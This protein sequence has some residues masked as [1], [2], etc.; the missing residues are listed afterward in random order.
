[1]IVYCS[2]HTGILASLI[3][4][5]LKLNITFIICFHNVRADIYQIGNTTEFL[6]VPTIKTFDSNL[7]TEYIKPNLSVSRDTKVH[8]DNCEKRMHGS[9]SGRIA[10]FR[11]IAPTLETTLL[12]RS[13][14]VALCLH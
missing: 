4:Y 5:L 1:M 10:Q 3:E 14:S 9:C 11:Q 8:A 2:L 12:K 7:V 13:S 6:A